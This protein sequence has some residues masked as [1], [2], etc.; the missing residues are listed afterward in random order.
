MRLKDYNS[1]FTGVNWEGVDNDI[2]GFRNELYELFPDKVKVTSAKRY[3]NNVGKSGNKSRHNR[4]QAVDL[5]FDKD[6][7]KFL[8]TAK[9]DALLRKY[10][11]GFLD[12]SL[13]HNLKKTGGTGA[14]FH[15]GKDSTLV[16]NSYAGNTAYKAESHTMLDEHNH[17]SQSEV[18]A[19]NGLPGVNQQTAE[20]NKFY[21][22]T[23]KQL[24]S[25]RDQAEKDFLDKKAA[26]DRQ[27]AI[28]E[29]LK[30]KYEE[31]LG[32]L[33]MIKNNELTSVS[34]D[35]GRASLELGG[36]IPM[37]IGGGEF[38]GLND[39]IQYQIEQV[40][41]QMPD[42][43]IEN[44]EDSEEFIRLKSI[45]DTLNS[46]LSNPPANNT[47]SNTGDTNFRNNQLQETANQPKEP[48][49]QTEKKGVAFK[50]SDKLKS[51]GLQPHQ[52][53]GVLGSLSLESFENI[54]PL[55]HNKESN[56]F[57]IAQW[58]GDRLTGLKEFGKS[59]GRDFKNED[60]QIDYLIH[61]IQNNNY[62]KRVLPLLKKAKTVEEATQIWTKIYERPS[63]KEIAKTMSSR[64]KNAKMFQSKIS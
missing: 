47:A 17:A 45:D 22:E 9:G 1:I 56:A 16:G 61:E 54:N 38:Q 15:I 53:A 33:E 43:S 41:N 12:E 35:R 58:L 57:G 26:T 50:L 29:E 24:M 64:I 44:T 59:R 39:N 48:V 51:I 18:D 10:N 63:P 42:F 34:R 6:I 4:G 49:N 31:K 46:L 21:E 11:L 32:I 55:A 40:K 8:Y 62:E 25:Q 30:R 7:Q 20:Q 28:Q 14:H 13:E 37:F 52:I 60:I 27:N 19:A 5:G 3:G 2:I 23:I 36:E